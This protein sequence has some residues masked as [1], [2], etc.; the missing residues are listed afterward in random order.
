MLRS[1]PQSITPPLTLKDLLLRRDP[2]SE[3][4]SDGMMVASALVCL[5]WSIVQTLLP[6]RYF[7]SW[8]HAAIVVY[9]SLALTGTWTN[10]TVQ[11]ALW[12]I[13]LYLPPSSAAILVYAP[14][15]RQTL[16]RECGPSLMM[17]HQLV[18][19]LLPSGV[20]FGLTLPPRPPPGTAT[21]AFLIFLVVYNAALLV[22]WGTTVMDNYFVRT[23]VMV[24]WSAIVV[25][26]AV[27]GEV[28]FATV[29]RS[30]TLTRLIG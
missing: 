6:P 4:C 20:V 1:P 17:L 10:A 8:C 3:T 14:E 24:I 29:G 16:Q 11:G 26:S 12:I 28:L 13:A 18:V 7:T 15:L 2:C 21:L 27:V 30:T 19:H 25:M 22:L 9:C 23:S 5:P